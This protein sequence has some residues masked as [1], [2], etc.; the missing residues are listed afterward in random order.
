MTVFFKLIKELT[1]A[2]SKK[3]RKLATS[4]D[5]SYFSGMFRDSAL[6]DEKQELLISL[7]SCI[8]K[9]E[10]EKDDELSFKKLIKEIKACRREAKNKSDEKGYTEG[11]FGPGIMSLLSLIDTIKEKFMRLELLDIKMEDKPYDIFCFYAGKY[12]IE[13]EVEKIDRSWFGNTIKSPLLSNSFQVA[14]RKDEILIIAVNKCRIRLGNTKNKDSLE[15]CL[16]NKKANKLKL[17]P[18]ITSRPIDEKTF[19][20]E[21]ICD[22][23]LKNEGVCRENKS[24]TPGKLYEYMKKAQEEIDAIPSQYEQAQYPRVSY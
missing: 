12:W 23:L 6:S 10:D 24:V 15:V 1:I 22:V 7:E 9:M 11:N 17:T 3:I 21:V 20:L 5:S 13:K 4:K 18:I 14:Q 8:K 16:K 2:R 19:I